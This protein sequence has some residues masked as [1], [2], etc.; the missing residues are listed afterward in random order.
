MDRQA[1]EFAAE[2]LQ[3]DVEA[4]DRQGWPKFASDR[5][6]QEAML[7]RILPDEPRADLGGD[8]LLRSADPRGLPQPTTPVSVSI[9]TRS[10]VRV[11]SSR[12]ETETPNGRLRSVLRRNASTLAILAGA[13]DSAC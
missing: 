4:A 13:E 9:R 7:E 11:L 12:T 5:P 2:V 1:E 3:G 8:R 10:V 6:P